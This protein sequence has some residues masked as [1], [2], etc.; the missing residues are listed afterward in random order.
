MPNSNKAATVGNIK[1]LYQ[2]LKAKFM[3]NYT[4]KELR[5]ALGLGDSAF[6]SVT[7]AP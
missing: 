1:A 5:E 4:M 3:P 7:S 2:Q 6:S